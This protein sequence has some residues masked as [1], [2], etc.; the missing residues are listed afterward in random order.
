MKQIK[1]IGQQP[2][3]PDMTQLDMSKL[4][5]ILW[6]NLYAMLRVPLT[7]SFF[8]VLLVLSCISQD[9]PVIIGSVVLLVIS[10]MLEYK[11]G[12]LSDYKNQHRSARRYVKN[13]GFW[14]LFKP[15]KRE[16]VSW[17]EIPKQVYEFTDEKNHSRGAAQ[18]EFGLGD[19]ERTERLNVLIDYFTDK[20]V[21]IVN[22]R[23]DQPINAPVDTNSTY[24]GT[25]MAKACLI[26]AAD[27]T[28]TNLI[29]A[30]IEEYNKPV[31]QSKHIHT[32]SEEVSPEFVKISQQIEEDLKSQEQ[33]A[34]ARIREES[35]DLLTD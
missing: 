6:Q 5:G 30:V 26:V 35:I 3:S 16:T 23:P 9:V 34:R 1:K 8:S 20:V 29:Q 4:Q 15:I 28:V 18:F 17:T 32:I 22:D 25:K 12:G 33:E 10:F 14:N 7:L 31:E 27:E 11:F 24:V 21:A 19:A 2:V 13:T